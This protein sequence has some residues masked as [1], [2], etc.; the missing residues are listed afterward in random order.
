M[1]GNDRAEVGQLRDRSH[2]DWSAGAAPD[3]QIPD[4][5]DRLRNGNLVG[6]AGIRDFSLVDR[7]AAYDQFEGHTPAA[8]ESGPG[9]E[10]VSNPCHSSSGLTSITLPR[11]AKRG[12]AGARM[13]SLIRWRRPAS[14]RRPALTASPRT[15]ARIDVT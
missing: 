5:P 3:A 9:P 2:P 7:I 8:D 15:C 4:R 13:A 1:A 6:L 12:I 14:A 10:E 11:F